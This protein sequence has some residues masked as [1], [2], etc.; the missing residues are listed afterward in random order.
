MAGILA[1]ALQATKVTVSVIN[2][3]RDAPEDLSALS[4][5]LKNLSLLL[6]TTEQ[7]AYADKLQAEDAMIAQTLNE[8]AEQ[9][10]ESMNKL[11]D[12][13]RPY[14]VGRRAGISFVKSLAWRL[15]KDKLK[16]LTDKLR[17]SKASVQFAITVLG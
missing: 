11:N 9:C 15:D 6:Q 16:G 4:L 7:R 12:A 5:E 17:D 1:A 10:T 2:D 14:S 8:C 3:I 13:L